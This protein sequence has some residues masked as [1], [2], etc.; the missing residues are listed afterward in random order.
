MIFVSNQGI[1]SG[2]EN[3]GCMPQAL[4]GDSHSV[5]AA[6]V[7][8]ITLGTFVMNVGFYKPALLAR[9]VEA[10]ARL[11]DGRHRT[12]DRIDDLA[13]HLWQWTA[14]R[15]EPVCTRIAG[16]GHR[17]HRRQFGLSEQVEHG[18]SENLGRAVDQL[19]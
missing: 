12:R 1:A 7:T 19:G 9:D 16:T 17:E 13:F 2:P 5:T 14:H 11:T 10:V 18:G 15:G 6:D 8:E 4:V 3:M